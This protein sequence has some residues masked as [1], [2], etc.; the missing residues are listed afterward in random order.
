[1]ICPRDHV[2]DGPEDDRQPGSEDEASLLNEFNELLAVA[3]D[4][5]AVLI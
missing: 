3:R 1:M 5:G 4:R 2:L